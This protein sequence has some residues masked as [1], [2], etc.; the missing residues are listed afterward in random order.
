VSLNRNLIGSLSWSR[1]RLPY[2]WVAAAVLLPLPWLIPLASNWYTPSAACTVASV[3]DG[4]TLPATCGGEKVKIRLYCIDAPEM[5]QRPWGTMSRDQLRGLLPQGSRIEIRQIDKDRYG[6]VVGEVLK[7]NGDNLN[8]QM[9]L[10]GEAAVYPRYCSDDRYF[11]VQAVAK[12][13]RSGIWARAGLQQ[14]PWRY[15]HR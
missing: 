15:R 3:H 10:A 5:G 12:A 1:R 6:R 8:L 13:A 2:F 14:T 4:D 7:E 9:V 11:Q